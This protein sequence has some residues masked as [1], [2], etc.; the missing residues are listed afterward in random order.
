MSN[1]SRWKHHRVQFAKN[2]LRVSPRDYIPNL[3]YIMAQLTS[4][5]MIKVY[6]LFVILVISMK[7]HGQYKPVR[8]TEKTTQRKDSTVYT[9]QYSLGMLR[10][11]FEIDI[12]QDWFLDFMI[13]GTNEDRNYTQGTAFTYTKYDLGEAVLFLPLNLFHRLLFRGSIKD[14]IVKQPASVSLGVTAFTPRKLA[15]SLNPV[16]G[17]RPFANVVFLRTAYR[18]YNTKTKFF[19][20]NS[21]AYG[22]IGS[23]IGNTFQS[24][25]HKSIVVG[26]PTNI[27]WQ[28]QISDGGRPSFLFSHESLRSVIETEAKHQQIE[29][30]GSLYAKKSIFQPIGG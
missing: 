16:I 4:L 10:G 1:L 25:A 17:D 18:Y 26:R 8:F 6:F 2:K 27:G 23:N 22:I 13:P 30:G 20:T 5:S 29:D 14:H 12:D 3:C 28:Y 11:N 15:D 7:A 21:F 24:F 19:T 9:S